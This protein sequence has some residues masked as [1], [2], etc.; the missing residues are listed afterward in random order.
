MIKSCTCGAL[1]ALMLFLF[2]LPLYAQDSVRQTCKPVPYTQQII[3]V[4]L[5]A[6]G[7]V[8]LVNQHVNKAFNDWLP[9]AHTE[10]DDYIQYLPMA[11]MYIADIAGVKAKNSVW[12]QTKYLAISQ[13]ATAIV[14]QTLKYTVQ[15]QRPNN[16]AYNSFPSGHTSV[17]FTGA[18]VLYHEFK[19]S[20][21]LIAYSGFAVAT[22]V[23][24]LRMTNERHWLSDVLA[25]AGIG[26]L[27]ANLVYY[28]E[29]LKNWQPFSKKSDKI[30][31]FPYY[32]GQCTGAMF[33]LRF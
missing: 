9:N 8:L 23:G 14:V 21:K 5:I 18:T 17:A 16:G 30:S 11:G 31:L 25:G 28:F 4:A 10:V 29:P 19:D 7:S 2:V 15:E 20:N 12:D 6:T 1:A 27:S 24:V 13:L 22:V 33:A 26:M 3:P 32:D